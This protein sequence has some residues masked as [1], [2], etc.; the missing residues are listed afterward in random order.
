MYYS[1]K[2]IQEMDRV[3]RLNLMNS[4]SGIKPVN[5]I[6][7]KS[8]SGHSNLAIIS[9]V[10]HLGSSPALIGFIVRPRG[11]YRRDTYDNIKENECFTVNHV[12][13]EIN[14]KAHYTSAKF[15]ADESEFE[16]CNLTEEYIANFPAPVCKRKR[17][18]IGPSA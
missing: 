7:T 4:I 2:D 3:E 17:Y 10:V 9:S 6:G 16:R 18:Q 14:E 5:L 1:G 11:K 12:N 8:T 13:R 15:E